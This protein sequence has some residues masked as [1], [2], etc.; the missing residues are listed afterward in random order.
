MRDV[1]G[2]TEAYFC[3]IKHKQKKSLKTHQQWQTIAFKQ[4]ADFDFGAYLSQVRSNLENSAD[5]NASPVLH[6]LKN[7]ADT[8]LNLFESHAV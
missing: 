1:I 7:S 6:S 3:P 4:A 2:A 8:Q 5:A